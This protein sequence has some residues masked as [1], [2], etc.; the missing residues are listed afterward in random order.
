VQ[1]TA[2][3]LLVLGD[4]AE[5]HPLPLELLATRHFGGVRKTALNR[6]RLLV[7]AGYLT[8]ERI[9]L[10]DRPSPIAFYS[11]TAKGRAALVRFTVLGQRVADA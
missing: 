11:S 9:Q 7:T 5:R 2:R 8:C 4:V 1:L 10:L 3:D 6:L